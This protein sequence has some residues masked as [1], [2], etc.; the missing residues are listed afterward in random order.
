MTNLFLAMRPSDLP[1][2]AMTDGSTIVISPAIVTMTVACFGLFVNIH[3]W[4]VLTPTTS[5]VY[6][7]LIE[8]KTGI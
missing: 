2:N 8:K 5:S 3:M 7:G 1:L 6:F 4:T